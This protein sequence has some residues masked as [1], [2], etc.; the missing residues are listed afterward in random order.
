MTNQWTPQPQLRSCIAVKGQN[1]PVLVENT[2]LSGTLQPLQAT[3]QLNTP[4]PANLQ[5]AFTEE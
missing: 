2:I 3:T 1:T 5:A 4:Q